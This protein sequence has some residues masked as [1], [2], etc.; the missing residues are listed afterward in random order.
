MEAVIFVAG[1]LSACVSACKNRSTCSNTCDRTPHNP[2]RIASSLDD[3][4]NNLVVDGR[5][6][7]DEFAQLRLLVAVVQELLAARC[8]AK[9]W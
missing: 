1:T 3:D 9:E 6:M 4:D 5:Q 7:G 2:F 8:T